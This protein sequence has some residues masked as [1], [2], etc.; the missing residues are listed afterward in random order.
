M[1]KLILFFTAVAMVGCSSDDDSSNSGGGTTFSFDETEYQ[2][3]PGVS[4]TEIIMAEVI[5][6][7]GES[8]DRSTISVTGVSGTSSTASITFDLYYKTGTS[9]AGTYNIYDSEADGSTDFNDFLE[10]QNRGCMGWTSAGIIFSLSGGTSMTSGNNPT[11]TVEVIVNSESNYTLKYNGNFRLYNNGFDFVRNMP[12]NI[13]VTSD[14]MI[15][16]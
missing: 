12:A 9:V 3:Q 11:G 5:D 4:M 2:L 7:N 15:Q 1:K 16:D 10:G 14:V 13:N 8:Y 6:V